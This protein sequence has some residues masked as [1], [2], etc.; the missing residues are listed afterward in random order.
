MIFPREN[1]TSC[2]SRPSASSWRSEEHTSELQSHDNLVCRLLLEKKSQL[3][4]HPAL[5][6]RIRSDSPR[7]LSAALSFSCSFSLPFC[8][9][10]PRGWPGPRSFRQTNTCFVNGG[11]IGERRS[12]RV[13]RASSG[14]R[15]PDR[16]RERFRNRA[17]RPAC[18]LAPTDRPP[19]RGA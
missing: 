16:G 1:W 6:A 15:S 14:R 10:E 11:L 4:R 18:P 12:L 5:L 3:S 8:A 9:Q 13:S 2:T 17:P 19:W 7:A